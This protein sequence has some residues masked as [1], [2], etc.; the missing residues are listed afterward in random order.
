MGTAQKKKFF[1]KDFYCKWDQIRS[2]L[3]IWS[4]LQKK[5]LME[6]LIFCQLGNS[7]YPGSFQ[8][9]SVSSSF[10]WVF[11]VYFIPG[12]TKGRRKTF[13]ERTSIDLSSKLSFTCGRNVNSYKSVHHPIP[14]LSVGTE[15]TLAILKP[16]QKALLSI[17]CPGIFSFWWK[18]IPEEDL[19]GECKKGV[20]CEIS[21]KSTWL[22]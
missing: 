6:N 9:K 13:L 2:F 15:N 18:W 4:H 1:I 10:K 22:S 11:Q 17:E 5:Y 20:H 19:F 8:N 16:N 14:T 3:R 7:D 12:Q 21:P